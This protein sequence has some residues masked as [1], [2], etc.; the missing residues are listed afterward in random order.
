MSN[1]LVPGCSIPC[2]IFLGGMVISILISGTASAETH[3]RCRGANVVVHSPDEA[4]ALTACDGAADAIIFLTSQGLD[5]GAEIEMNI[6]QKLPE[7]CGHS[8][9]GCYLE[10]K[11]WVLVLLYSEFNKQKT[12]FNLPIGRT[13]YRGL[14]SHEIAHDVAACNFKVANPSIQAKEYIA[15]VTMFST[16]APRLRE[17]VLKQFPGEGF[18]GDWQ[19]ST[20]IYMLDPM[21]FGAQAYRHFLKLANGREYLHAILSGKALIE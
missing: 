19:M 7:G 2:W 10:S 9:A 13:L 21:R 15:N 11:R 1:S 4:D 12:W 17:Q 3:I 16:M 8:A 6:V 20:T 5:A 14:V 18:E